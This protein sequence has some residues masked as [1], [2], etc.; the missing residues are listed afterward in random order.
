MAENPSYIE[1][2]IGHEDD[3]YNIYLVDQSGTI[4]YQIVVNQDGRFEQIYEDFGNSLKTLPKK[5]ID[6]F[7]RAQIIK[8]INSI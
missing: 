4:A 7:L 3:N 5:D 8:F 2:V 1:V 6:N